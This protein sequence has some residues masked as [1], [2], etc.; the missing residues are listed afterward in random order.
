MWVEVRPVSRAQVSALNSL[1]RSNLQGMLR[2]RWTFS[3]RLS[4][5]SRGIARVFAR[6]PCR[7]NREFASVDQG[8]VSRVAA[9]FDD[10]MSAVLGKRLMSAFDPKRPLAL[11]YISIHSGL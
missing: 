10:K 9:Y 11:A 3:P 1:K 2:F 8:S 5:L 6:I 7:L 4:L